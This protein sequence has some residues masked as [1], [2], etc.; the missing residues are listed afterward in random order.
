[1]PSGPSYRNAG[2]QPPRRD[3]APSEHVWRARSAVSEPFSVAGRPPCGTFYLTHQ[4]TTSLEATPAKHEP[5]QHSKKNKLFF[6]VLWVFSAYVYNN[7]EKPPPSPKFCA[8]VTYIHHLFTTSYVVHQPLPHRARMGPGFEFPNLI[9]R[10]WELCR[11]SL[12][13]F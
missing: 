13:G 9:S 10:Y 7:R 2:L 8:G 3:P 12:P 11:S 6:F 1:M 4:P 5:M